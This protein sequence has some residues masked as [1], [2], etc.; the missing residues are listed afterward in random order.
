M[1]EKVTWQNVCFMVGD[2]V[3]TDR[4]KACTSFWYFAWIQ[5]LKTGCTQT[6]VFKMQC[7]YSCKKARN[8]GLL[9]IFNF[10]WRRKNHY[11]ILDLFVEYWL[12][13]R[14]V[15]GFF[16]MRFLIMYTLMYTVFSGALVRSHCLHPSRSRCVTM[17]RLVVLRARTGHEI[18]VLLWQWYQKNLPVSHKADM[19]VL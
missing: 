8:I 7:I 16:L 18:G 17:F 15:A 6:V 19:R 3:L 1:F 11:S 9:G 14:I 2:E 5:T 10:F 12:Q 13:C 4:V